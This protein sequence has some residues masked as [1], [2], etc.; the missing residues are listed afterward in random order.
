MQSQLA[1]IMQGKM[2]KNAGNSLSV[3]KDFKCPDL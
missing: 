3:Q 2:T 1:S